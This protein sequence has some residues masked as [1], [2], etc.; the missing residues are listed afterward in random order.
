AR[1]FFPHLLNK[2]VPEFHKE[3]YGDLLNP[4]YYACAAPRGHAKSTIGLII[5]PIHYALF[6]ASGDITLLSASESFIVNEITRKI[7]HEFEHNEL[8]I[9]L[10]KD[11][12]TIKWA[13]TYFVLKNGVAFEA[14]GI[15]GQLRGGRRGLIALDDLETNETVESEEQRS[16]LRDRVNKELIPKLIPGGQLIYFGTIISPLCYLNS[17]ISTPDNGWTK[18]FYAA[19]WDLKNKCMLPQEKGNELWAEMLPHEEL[20]RRKQVQ[21]TNSFS[22]EYLN[23]PVSDE[24][25]PIKEGQIRYWKEFPQTYSSVLTVDPAY[26]DDEKAD[27]KT[28]SHI[29]IDQQMN[30]YLASYIRTHAPIGEFQDAIINL[31]LQN[32]N[33]VT[34]VGIPNSGVEK[35]FFDSFLKKCDERKLYP[36]VVELKNAFTQTGTS[37]SQRGK[38]ARCTA[39]LQPLFEQGK[40][41]I[42]PDHIEAREELLTI[43]SSRWDD[44]VDTMAYAE[45]ILVPNYFP[46]EKVDEHTQ[47]IRQHEEEERINFA[48]G[49]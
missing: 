15:G 46:I 27:F 23:T 10:F 49:L 3:I 42:H 7:K 14:G 29:A 20:Q 21:G 19:Y 11:Q 34:A 35:S 28:C 36:P 18:R 45:Q 1:D 17:I 31:W 44:L 41:F 24:T 6:N 47:E 38:K 8:L 16:K 33:T 37:I 12:K 9:K 48:Y 22:S 40:Y 32:K 25:Q 26:S 4:N 5:K 39:A 13:E 30:R 43:G 2:S